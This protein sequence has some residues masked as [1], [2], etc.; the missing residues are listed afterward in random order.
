VLVYF[1]TAVEADFVYL[2]TE[3][4]SAICVNPSVT[5][6]DPP[7]FSY[8]NIPLIDVTINELYGANVTRLPSEGEGHNRAHLEITG[9]KSTLN[10][11]TVG[12]LVG[13]TVIWR[14]HLIR[15]GN[16]LIDFE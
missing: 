12:C 4:F 3:E 13:S 11:S 14:V 1:I 2:D 8:N 9:G 16:F 5:S 15:N 6:S 7:L 10:D